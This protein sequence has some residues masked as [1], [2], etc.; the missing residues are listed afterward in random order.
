L[1]KTKRALPEFVGA[2]GLSPKEGMAATRRSNLP[3]ADFF[4]LAYKALV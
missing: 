1:L 4:R 2:V 3:A